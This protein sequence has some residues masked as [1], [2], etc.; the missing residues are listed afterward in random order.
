MPEDELPL[1]TVLLPVY[2]EPEIVQNLI[3]G[4]AQLDYPLDKLE[5]LLLTEEDD[6]APGGAEGLH[7]ERVTVVV[8]PHSLPKTK[9]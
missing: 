8:V 3:H 9:P 2:F 7:L 6:T 4:L 5:V 1:Y